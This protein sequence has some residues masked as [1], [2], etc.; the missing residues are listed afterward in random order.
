MAR[1]QDAL[2]QR[3]KIAELKRLITSGAYNTFEQLED[4]VDALLWN[5]LDQAD[6][7]EE[8]EGLDALRLTAR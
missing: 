6:E 1:F 5:D 2:E 7:V 4:A 8:P 3:A